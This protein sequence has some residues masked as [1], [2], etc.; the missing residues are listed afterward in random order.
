MRSPCVRV[1]TA[2]ALLLVSSLALAW[3][4]AVATDEDCNRSSIDPCIREG[5]CT[6]Q[7]GQCIATRE[8]DCRASWLCSQHGWCGLREG[9]CQAVAAADCAKTE[10]CAK[11]GTCS[12]REGRCVVGSDRD[13]QRSRRCT[14]YGLCT[15]DATAES[16]SKDVTCPD[17][18]A[19]C[20]ACQNVGVCRVTNDAD[21]RASDE[22]RF[23]GSCTASGGAC[24]ATK[25][26][27]CR[28]AK[29]CK[30]RGLCTLKDGQCIAASNA[31]C[32]ASDECR[33]SGTCFVDK[34]G[35]GECVA[36]ADADCKRS[37][38]CKLNGHC[39]LSPTYCSASDEGGRCAVDSEGCMQLCGGR[40]VADREGCKRSVGCKKHGAC[41]VYCGSC[42]TRREDCPDELSG[43]GQ[44]ESAGREGQAAQGS[45][46][47][48]PSA[49]RGRQ[50]RL[51]PAQ[52][53]LS[54]TQSVPRSPQAPD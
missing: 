28:Q 12:Q 14:R 47:E 20:T 24:R 26:L 22:C 48:P 27:D 41:E 1:S 2:I 17:S 40:C 42:R 50:G 39:S 4:A 18:H 8:A 37:L 19:P 35:E 44:S 6:A 7:G 38:I 32:R 43:R 36:M 31:D 15:L 45:G 16:C 9:R 23:H 54:R 10:G 33:E 34:G 30:Q 5:R 51:S 3:A 25:D 53:V 49:G 52:S 13:C 46:S 21:C 29:A 11:G